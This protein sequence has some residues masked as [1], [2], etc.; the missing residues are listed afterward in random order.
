MK[1]W[2]ISRTLQNHLAPWPGDTPFTFGLVSRIG[3]G[4]SVNIGAITMS[5]HNGTHADAPFHFDPSGATIDAAALEKYFGPALVVDLEGRFSE[6]RQLIQIDDLR[7][8]EMKIAKAGRLLIKTGT[9]R[10]SSVFPAWIPVLAPDV[11]DWLQAKKVVLVGFDVPSVDPV[12]AKI[13]AN[14]H[15][16]TRGGI[17]IVESLDLSGVAEGLYHMA[18]LPLKIS[19]ADGAPLRAVL[20][21]E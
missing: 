1:I 6:T 20:W 5:V 21:R 18:A 17:G 10:D 3:P 2:D 9:W 19:G 15:A 11:A 4:S 16:L 13:L 14:H 7:P 12:D 8:N